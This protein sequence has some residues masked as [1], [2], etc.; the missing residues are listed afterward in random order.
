M[1]FDE[2]GR[3]LPD[4]TPVSVP[5]GWARPPSIQDL[6]RQF[7][8]QEFSR[9]ALQDEQETF[10]E[11]DDFE[12]DEDPDPL[13]QYELPL[14]A[15]EWLGGEKDADA[16]PPPNPGEKS[17][18]EAPDASQGHSEGSPPSTDSGT[19]KPPAGGSSRS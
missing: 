5:S 8:R 6:M 1:K 2:R 15:P 3:E 19:A 18:V 12:V 13:S 16:A 11:A 7:I 14:A 10:E 9:Q 4:P 17:L